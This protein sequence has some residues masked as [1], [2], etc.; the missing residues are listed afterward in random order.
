MPPHSHQERLPPLG[1]D[2]EARTRR[3]IW[4]IWTALTLTFLGLWLATPVREAAGAI[5]WLKK[6][7]L[8][9]LYLMWPLWQGGRLLLQ[10]MREAPLEAWHGSY[11]A[12]EDFQIRV[13]VDED[14]RLLFVAS[15]VLDALR[16]EGRGRQPERIRAI[17]GRDG[18]RAVAAMRVLVFTE[19]G[20][21][22]WLERNSR[23]DVARFA[24]WL[25]NQ[26]FEPHRRRLERGW[27]N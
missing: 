10:K 6:A 25:R 4:W 24:H 14:D 7:P 11:Y 17:V 22:A 5:P 12:F 18:L 9:A 21:H 26:V 16:I 8:I 13:L 27:T 2:P 19:T 23:R 15:D 3:S 1:D 20:L